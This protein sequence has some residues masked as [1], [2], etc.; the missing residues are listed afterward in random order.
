MRVELDKIL[1]IHRTLRN[2]V[3]R[4]HAVVQFRLIRSHVLYRPQ[5]FQKPISLFLRKSWNEVG[6]LTEF[7]AGVSKIQGESIRIFLSLFNKC[8]LTRSTCV[9]SNGMFSE[10][11]WE[12]Q[13]KNW[14]SGFC[15]VLFVEQSE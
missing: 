8:L 6:L 2:E 9:A 12:G 10:S 5:I 3:G 7:T 11:D 4:T 13:R 1:N 14:I 15:K